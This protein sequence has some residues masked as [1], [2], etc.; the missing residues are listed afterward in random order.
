MPA[1]KTKKP[2]LMDV[3]TGEVIDGEGAINR[4]RAMARKQV[5]VDDAVARVDLEKRA[6]RAAKEQLEE[7]RTAMQ[8]RK[9]ELAELV[10][11]QTLMFE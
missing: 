11:G 6:V 7:A 9:D 1:T 8:A 10:A 5:E 2:G 3:A 4:L